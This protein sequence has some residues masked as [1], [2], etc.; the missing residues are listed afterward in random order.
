VIVHVEGP[1]RTVPTPA[2]FIELR[3]RIVGGGTEVTCLRTFHGEPGPNAVVR[4]NATIA[5]HLPHRL[6]RYRVLIVDRFAADGKHARQTVTGK[7]I[8]GGGTFTE[9]PPGNVSASN[10]TYRLP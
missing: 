9:S 6:L 10:L 3:A 8:R 4:L 7:G 2:C 5:F 1:A